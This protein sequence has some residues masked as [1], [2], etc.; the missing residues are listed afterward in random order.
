[1]AAAVVAA[2]GVRS[3]RG[4]VAVGMLAAACGLSLAAPAAGEP[5]VYR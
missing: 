2:N 3:W 5:Q 1:M 4:R